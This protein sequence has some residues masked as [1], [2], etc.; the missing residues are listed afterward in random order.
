MSSIQGITLPVV[1]L[2][3]ICKDATDVDEPTYVHESNSNGNG[4]YAQDGGG[5]DQNTVV[6][7]HSTA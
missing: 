3:T 6:H 4:A 7:V 1:T 2:L 5:S